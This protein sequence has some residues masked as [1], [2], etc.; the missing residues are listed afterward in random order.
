MSQ[1]DLLGVVV[2]GISLTIIMLGSEVSGGLINVSSRGSQGLS[3]SLFNPIKFTSR[4]LSDMLRVFQG[5]VPL[6]E[7]FTLDFLKLIGC[8]QPLL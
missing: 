6:L 3:F 1:S 4:I 7:I 5:D 2:S 8:I